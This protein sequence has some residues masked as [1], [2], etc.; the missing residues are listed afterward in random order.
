LLIKSLKNGESLAHPSALTLVEL[1]ES[2]ATVGD[3]ENARA[4]ADEAERL[5]SAHGFYELTYRL[6]NPILVAKP[7]PLAPATEEIIAAVDELEGA[8]LVAVG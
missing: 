4:L 6:E 2:L 8:E 7:A 5:A 1:S 3:D